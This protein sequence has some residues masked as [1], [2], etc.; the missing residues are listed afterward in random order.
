M[1]GQWS[2]R[3][4]QVPQGSDSSME[5]AEQQKGTQD[6]MAFYQNKGTEKF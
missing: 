6:S 3:E 2:D 5:Q 4:Y 1:L